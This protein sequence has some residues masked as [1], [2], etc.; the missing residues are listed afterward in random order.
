VI[1]IESLKVS[2]GFLADLNIQFVP[3]LNTIIGPRGTGKTSV[4]ELIRYC[5][6]S[7]TLSERLNIATLNHAKAILG[8]GVASV[9]MR[10]GNEMLALSRGSNDEAPRV[11]RWSRP[12]ILA[13]NEIESIGLDA[14]SRVALLDGFDERSESTLDENETSLRALQVEI[15]AIREEVK[16]LTDQLED[17][18]GI[19]AQLAE[20]DNRIAMLASKN[21]EL[22][23]LQERVSI[24]ER[25]LGELQ[26]HLDD[27]VVAMQRV[28]SLSVALLRMQ[29]DVEYLEAAAKRIGKADLTSAA[30][31]VHRGSLE[32]REAIQRSSD[33]LARERDTDLS[34]LEALRLAISPA[35]AELQLSS[36]EFAAV[37]RQ[38]RVV[39]ERARER[40]RLIARLREREQRLDSLKRERQQ[41]LSLLR[42]KTAERT[43]RRIAI[44]TSI[45]DQLAPE[46]RTSVIPAG[47][48]EDY[49]SRLLDA[50][51]GSGL[52]AAALA[53]QIAKSVA[54]EELVYYVEAGDYQELARSSRITAE[55][56]ARVISA[57]EKTDL[58][59]VLTS[60]IDDDVCLELLD[61]IDYKD[62]TQLSTGQRCTVILPI[63]LSRDN[64]PLIL[65][66]PED[67][68]DNAFIVETLVKAILARK[69]SVQIIATT[70]NANIPVLGDAEHVVHLESNGRIGFIRVEGELFDPDVVQSI[71][72]IMEGGA[73]AFRARA[74]F[75]G[76]ALLS[77]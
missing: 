48:L 58:A 2:G 6:G 47:S 71:T 64:A 51:K 40:N 23:T 11:A 16:N 13:Q 20:F 8:N 52:H 73:D 30:N 35:R 57:L 25:E 5:L 28:D 36:S 10:D 44:A 72:N 21:K 39:E 76:D 24:T 32:L 22:T 67:H 53:P 34:R 19:D 69:S 46:I 62:T 45:T 7:R 49:T 56:A 63:L 66:Q 60:Q 59:S 70:H 65:D 50:F 26:I 1:L 18:S 12:F 15:T 42:G 68:L 29:P 61:G 4:I 54:P 14:A 37:T 17:F 27:I 33:A 41:L 38:A 55:R 74:Q 75:Y 77:A 43:R 31:S 9:V 3:G